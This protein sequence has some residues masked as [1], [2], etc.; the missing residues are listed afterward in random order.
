VGLRWS[1]EV[2]DYQQARKILLPGRQESERSDERLAGGLDG[3]SAG[4]IDGSKN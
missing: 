3:V 1:E 4:P 2:S